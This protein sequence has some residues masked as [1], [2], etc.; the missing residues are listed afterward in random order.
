MT[1]PSTDRANWI[2]FR[3]DRHGLTTP[4]DMD[5]TACDQL[6]RLGV[7]DS[8]DGAAVEALAARG[9]DVRPP[10]DSE[11]SKPEDLIVVW[12]VRGAPH[13][14][15][16]RDLERVRAA[17]HVVDDDDADTRMAGWQKRVAGH[18]TPARMLADVSAAMDDVVTGPISKG[19]LSTEVSRRLPDE[20]FWCETCKAQHVPDITFRLAA[21]Q[22]RL[23]VVRT[24]PTVLAPW[25][26]AARTGAVNADEARAGLARAF[27]RVQGPTSLTLLTTWLGAGRHSMDAAW[28]NVGDVQPVTV[29]GRRYSVLADNLDAYL[30][31]D[32]AG[33][34]WAA[35]VPGKDPYLQAADK[36]LLV[37]GSED[38]RR[39]WRPVQWPGALLVD[40][41]VA[42]TWRSRTHA[43]GIT[44]IVTPFEPAAKATLAQVEV[45]AMRLT[46]V[47]GLERVEVDWI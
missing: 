34:G 45:A 42:G 18:V 41:E 9:D 38:R 27:L 44:V 1:I 19:D 29:A 11:P 46:A 2:A 37:P 20:T 30:S 21:L 31:A 25:P 47:R 33:H 43:D 17:L 7:Q 6:L 40:G 3:C 32:P 35:L 10:S 14:H 13:V 4:E 26:Q 16:L 23:Y 22:A 39:V 12:S 5:S 8:P 24:N 36:H 15:R 28:A